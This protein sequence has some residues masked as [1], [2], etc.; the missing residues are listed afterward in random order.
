M[1]TTLKAANHQKKFVSSLPIYSTSNFTTSWDEEDLL[2][3]GS[4][5]TARRCNHNKLGRVVAKCF[6]FKG[7]F[8]AKEKTIADVTREMKVLYRLKHKNI[9]RIYGITEWSD[10]IG[11]IMEYIDAGNLDFF[12]WIQGDIAH[13]PLLL[14]IRFAHQI[15]DG[16]SYLHHHD[17]KRSFV[18]CDL[19]PENILVTSD[20]TLKIA[21]FGSVAIAKATGVTKGSITITQNTQHT[22]FYTAPELLRDLLSDKKPHNDVYSYGMVL[23]A[24]LTRHPAFSS[25]DPVN[26]GLIIELIIQRGQKPR[27]Q[28]L[29]D[30]ESSLKNKP[31]DLKIFKFLEEIMIQCWDFQPKNRPSIKTVYEG[32]DQ[33]LRSLN[34]SDVTFHISDLK[35]DEEPEPT[36]NSMKIKLSEFSPP[37]EVGPQKPIVVSPVEAR[38]QQSIARLPIS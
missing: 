7:L 35:K 21:D 22:P 17:K 31:E 5:A 28:Y 32:I 25:D 1:A 6:H 29:D 13:I 34:K 4:F 33:K 38:P 16:L 9:V 11:I 12:L 20:L 26:S 2:G 23:Y 14:Q 36:R 15:S 19:K 30:V 37:F 8:K 24:I 18:H 27:Q 3:S 10:C